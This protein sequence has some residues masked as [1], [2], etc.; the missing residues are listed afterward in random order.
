MASAELAIPFSLLFGFPG[1][2]VHCSVLRPPGHRASDAPGWH[3]RVVHSLV[4]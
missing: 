1:L 4:R 2:T 3:S